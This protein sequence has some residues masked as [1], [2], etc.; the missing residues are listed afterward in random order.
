M[1][2]CRPLA[3]RGLRTE[4]P[5]PPEAAPLLFAASFTLYL[6]LTLLIDA[7]AAPRGRFAGR[8]LWGQLTAVLTLSLLF[9]VWFA[10]SWRPIFAAVSA[11]ITYT[12]IVLISDYKFR[13]VQEPLN[14]VDFALIPQIWRHPVLYQAPYLHH[15]AFFAG[16]AALLGIIV[17]WCRFVEPSL[18]PDGHVW[19]VA[20]PAGVVL[21]MVIGWAVAGPLPSR[22]TA[23]VHRRM[24]PA[25]STRHVR[26]L[27]LAASLAAG[28]V[29][30]RH[31][32][33]RSRTWPVAVPSVRPLPD[34][35]S[36]VVIAVQSESFMDLRRAGLHDVK[37][38]GLEHAR[39]QA[40]AYGRVAV[41]VQ[42]AW[43]LRSE[44]AFL[45]GCPLDEFGL[46]A[47]HPYLR[48]AKPPR[49]LA[50]HLGDA[51]FATAF[52]HPFDLDFFNRRVAM[53]RL[54]FDRLVD[55][56]D[57]AGVAREGYYVPDMAL[58]EYALA[59]AAKEKQ[60]LFCMIATMENHNPW[61]KD[62][63]PGIETPVD[64]YVYHLRNA[65]RMIAHLIA[66]IERLG[67][68]AVLAFY[69]DHVPTMPE[70]ADPFP[71]PRTD[72]FVMGC[73]DGAWL[74]GQPRDCALH[75]M[76]DTILDALAWACDRPA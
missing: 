41:P 4:C 33:T 63:L 29:G 51:G 36:P 16:I 57:F 35:P 38:P 11:L 1:T 30:W 26:V 39:S 65:D 47:L 73:R 9:A 17:L 6:L 62:R 24:M 19:D 55:E 8:P 32:A 42:G 72:Y 58:A 34:G 66:G 49:T 31:A 75:E 53:P 64:R 68:P 74:P 37:L 60:P 10:V 56:G 50:H 59:M 76:A 52:V 69:G 20:V 21:A 5:W 14:F 45:A 13:N 18:L 7:L 46:D 22:L 28:L 15:P 2:L 61:D 54:G 23:A 3:M 25:D 40:V 27:G 12:I 67:R 71:D 70:L 48:L 44:F 43:T